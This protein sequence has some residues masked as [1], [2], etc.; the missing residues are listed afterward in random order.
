MY[1]HFGTR[2]HRVDWEQFTHVTGW[3]CPDV[4]ELR[5]ERLPWRELLFEERFRYCPICLECGYHSVWHQFRKLSLCPL[6]DVPLI[7]QCFYCGEVTSPLSDYKKSLHRPFACNL[8]KGYLAGAAPDLDLHLDLL[9]QSPAICAKLD[10]FK[11]WV[12][13]NHELLEIVQRL[14]GAYSDSG[15]KQT[16]FHHLLYRFVDQMAPAEEFA[17]SDGQTVGMFLWQILPFRTNLRVRREFHTRLSA[18]GAYRS[19]IHQ[20]LR[21]AVSCE[22]DRR[23]LRDAAR[24]IADQR[25]LNVRALGAPVVALALTRRWIE[26]EHWHVP[27]CTDAREALLSRAMPFPDCG[28]GRY[29]RIEVKA[30]VSALYSA[31]LEVSLSALN[32]RAT[33]LPR[34]L[35]RAAG[36]VVFSQWRQAEWITGIAIFPLLPIPCAPLRIHERLPFDSDTAPTD[37]DLSRPTPFFPY[38]WYLSR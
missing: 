3:S 5:I 22:D 16:A 15:K 23:R 11:Y 38:S 18:L 28:T 6:H 37:A 25:P 30:Y 19:S 34:T 4:V 9:D 32:Q 17:L 20:L 35:L 8:C 33:V 1:E 12:V 10:R 26:G 21:W 27:D 36:S 29:L 14:S 24:K 31:F 2:L 7:S 13:H